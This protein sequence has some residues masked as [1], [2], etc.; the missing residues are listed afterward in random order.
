MTS[1]AAMQ[2][3]LPFPDP[4]LDDGVVTL[5]RLVAADEDAIVRACNDG[6]TQRWLEFLPSPYLPEH[7]RRYVASAAVGWETGRAATFAIADARTGGLLG[8]LAIEEAIDR[9]PFLGC[10]IAPW[11]RGRGVGTRA[12][13]LASRWAVRQLGV[14]RLEVLVEPANT[15]S[16]RMTERAGFV[17]EGLLRN[18]QVGR[19]GPVD[20]LVY[21]LIPSDLEHE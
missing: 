11:A 3:G 10:G 1:D 19:E 8:T 13:V 14:T 18:Y 21:S 7:A 17:R 12:V 6:V 5:R 9:R 15:A 4:P 20:C 2:A 16:V